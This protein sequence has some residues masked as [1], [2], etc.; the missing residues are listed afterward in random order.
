MHP[1]LFS[2]HVLSVAG[3]RQAWSLP[4]LLLLSKSHLQAPGRLLGLRT[5]PKSATV[6]LPPPPSIFILPV[7]SNCTLHTK[8]GEVDESESQKH[9]DSNEKKEESCS[10]VE[11]SSWKTEI[12]A[13]IQREKGKD[14]RRL[15]EERLAA[16][17]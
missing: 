10:G 7:S 5:V 1:S 15:D 11:N 12:F 16:K 9:E 6:G 4:N 3:Q 14:C 2:V 17:C 8:H 13:G